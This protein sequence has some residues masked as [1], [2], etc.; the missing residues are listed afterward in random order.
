MTKLSLLFAGI[1]ASTLVGAA[2]QTDRPSS[3]IP[4]EDEAP[5][6]A[7]SYNWMDRHNSVVER[8]KQGHVDL[9][10]IGDSITHGWGGPP[11][12]T[13]GGDVGELWTKYFGSRNAVNEG[14]G[15]DR[16]QHV[17][18]RFD[19]GEID[20]IS[21]KVAVLL[22]G[23]NNVGSNKVGDVVLGI[24]AIVDE[25]QAKLPKTKTLLLGIFPRDE[26]PDTYNRKQVTEIN[27]LAAA[28]VGKQRGREAL[29]APGH[30]L[31]VPS[32]RRNNLA[33]GDGRFSAPHRQRLRHLGTR[34]G[35]NAS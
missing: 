16:T 13:K 21:P 23:T 3:V 10:L 28:S 32:T 8:V 18:W 9:L 27:A 6:K 4:A 33:R 30:Q 15:W 34:D 1:L 24:K 12:P 20:G 7:G 35:A 2:V 19:H 29:S 22:I 5:T 11:D 25:L 14:F 31:I 26:K 17:L